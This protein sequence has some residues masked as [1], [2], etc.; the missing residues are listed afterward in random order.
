LAAKVAIDRNR[1]R[2]GSLHNEWDQLLSKGQDLVHDLVPDEEAVLIDQSRRL[3]AAWSKFR[4]DLPKDQQVQIEG[5]DLPDINY[6]VVTVKKASETWQ[7]DR[8]GSKLGK[9][10]SKFHSLCE[11]C[12]DHSSLLSIIP[13]DDKYVTLLTGSLSAIAQATINHQNLAEGVADTLDD[14]S[15]DIDFWN[16]QM[17]EHGNIPSLRKYIQELYVVVFEFFTEIFNKWSKSGW[18]RLLTS[19]DNG[20]FNDI[21]TTKKDRLSAIERRM[22]RYVNLE[23]RHRTT[24]HLEKVIRNQ[25]EFMKHLPDQL[26][27]HRLFLGESIQ[28]LLEQ[29]QSFIL[30]A[31][32]TTLT[33][34]MVEGSTENPPASRTSDD[35]ESPSAELKVEQVSRANF[36]YNR[37]DIHAELTIFINQWMGQVKQLTQAAKQT[38]PFKIDNEVQH[39]MAKWQRGLSSANLWIHGPH[40]VSRPSQNT[41]TAVSMVALARTHNIP[42]VVYFCTLTD[43]QDFEESKRAFDAF[44][45]S[46]ITQLVQL[47]PEKGYAEAGL[48]PARFSALA[49]GSLDVE[50]KLQ[51][52][53]DVRDLGPRLLH[54]FIDN[55]QVLEDRSDEPYTRDFLRG[56]AALC[57]LDARSWL[58]ET[59][60]ASNTRD[61]VLGT[62]ICFTTDGYVDGLAQAEGLQLLDRVKFDLEIGDPLYN[63]DGVRIAWS[64]NNRDD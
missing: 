2:L 32:Q 60:V 24:L 42:C 12:Q 20:A 36:R 13:K 55:L 45:A 17:R 26:H 63:E 4:R 35:C 25:E 47:I 61:R 33:T 1:E 49:Q 6:L 30:E 3:H 44:I 37:A 29:R 21:F 53:S 64:I 52:L 9:L 18:K 7:S 23:F 11:T 46:I 54:I 22:E 19:F 39:R 10:K 62:K 38:S 43:Q 41:M 57:R 48:S 14:L 15:H 31:P 40:D 51:L 16:R 50:E 59:D 28:L 8:E 5:R 58:P 56:I 27:H 34:P